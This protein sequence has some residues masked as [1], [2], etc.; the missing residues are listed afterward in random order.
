ME[1]AKRD[2][3][4]LRNT[5]DEAAATYERFRPSYPDALYNDLISLTNLET[6]SRLLEVGCGPG[7]ATRPLARRGFKVTCLELGHELAELAR[8]SLAEYDVRV[9]TVAFEHWIPPPE[10]FDL[11]YAATAWHWIDPTVKYQRAWN[12]LRPG[13]HLAF[14]EALHVFPEGG[15]PFFKEIQDVYSSILGESTALRWPRPGELPENLDEIKSSGLFDVI[16]VRHYDWETIYTAEEYIG[17]LNTFSG[18]IAMAD[19]QRDRLYSEIR[20]FLASR[21]ANPEC[22]SGSVRRHWGCVLRI[23]R[24]R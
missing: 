3:E 18:H 6:D 8:Q 22:P 12:V 9:E 5:F 20:R 23:A 15:D 17:L 24:K 14:W 1:D 4:F 19:W 21:P 10:P 7:I 2:R 16:A 13:G 11:V